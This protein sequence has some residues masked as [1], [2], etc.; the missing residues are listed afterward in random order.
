MEYDAYYEAEQ[1]AY[2]AQAEAERE[3]DFD[4]FLT[5]LLQEGKT[6]LFAAY[7]AIDW[8]KSKEFT[9]SGLSPIAFLEAKRDKLQ[10]IRVDDWPPF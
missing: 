9:N 8:L 3:A 1:M 2:A 5:Q 10:E 6:A 4:A 7:V